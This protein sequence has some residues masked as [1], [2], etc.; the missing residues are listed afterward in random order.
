MPPRARSTAAA[1][2]LVWA[3]LALHHSCGRPIT[4]VGAP[5]L[6]WAAVRAQ[7]D[8]VKREQHILAQTC[9]PFVVKLF[10][11][12]QSHKARP[13]HPT[14]HDANDLMTMVWG[15]ICDDDGVAQDL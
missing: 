7:V 6:V 14:C 8:H 4:R 12:F 3:Q 9:N 1:P 13:L 10:Y 11:S 2:S 5:S 15:R